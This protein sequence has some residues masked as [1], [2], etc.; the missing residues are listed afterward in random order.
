[1]TMTNHL[2]GTDTLEALVHCRRTVLLRAT[3]LLDGR[4]DIPFVERFDAIPTL[5]ALLMTSL[6][7][8]KVAEEELREQNER[9]LAQR[10]ATEAQTRYYRQLFLHAP[11][12]AFVT[13]FY[14]TIHETNLAAAKLFRREAEHLERKPLA[15]LLAPERREAFRRQLRLMTETVDGVRDWAL[16]MQRVGDVPVTV[17]AEVEVVPNVGATNS[18]LLYWM[19]HVTGGN[20]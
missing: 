8:L 6:E 17:R 20:E 19:L 10:S 2:D 12:P 1:M 16:T 5:S 14:G 11:T 7:E 15:A 4:E 9:L 3:T 13:D 18:G